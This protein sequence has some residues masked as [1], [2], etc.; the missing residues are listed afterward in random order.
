MSIK[1]AK[2]RWRERLLS[3]PAPR[4]DWG[5]GY[6]PGYGQGIPIVTD[7]EAPYA[8][9]SLLS[10]ELAAH[11]PPMRSGDFASTIRRDLTLARIQDVVRN[12]PHAASAIDKLSDHI[13]GAEL[14]WMSRPDG[15]ALGISDRDALRSLAKQ[16]EAEWRLFA[17]DPRRFCDSTRRLSFNGLMR[18]CVRTALISG[19]NCYGL[20]KQKDPRARY[21]TAVLTI[22]PDRMCNPYGE[23]DTLT[24]RMGVEMDPDNGAPVGYWVRDAHLGDYWAPFEQMSW[25]FLPRETEWG[26]PVFVHAYE[27]LRDGDSRGTSPLITL[28]GRLRA[29]GR[30]TDSELASAAINALFSAT[31]ES[32]A[33]A[34]E[35]AER[36]TPKAQV[37]TAAKNWLDALSWYEKY[38]VRVGGAR[39]P[40]LLPGTTMKFNASPRQTAAFASFETAFLQTISSKLGLAYEQLKMDWSRTNYSS[41]RAALNEVWRG[42][43]RLRSAFVDQTVSPL[44]L[45][46]ADEAFDRGY[47]TEPK[48]APSFWDAVGAYLRG[49][50]IGPARGYV[51]PVKEMQASALR[52]DGRVSTWADECAEQGKDYE[53]V[54]DQLAIE[55]Q[56]LRERDLGDMP[57]TGAMLRGPTA[58]EDKEDTEQ[59][60]PSKAGA[61]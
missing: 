22:D 13:V 40:V 45:A 2:A 8:A 29:L 20:T 49:R 51:D 44:H 46:W 16:M 42:I 6:G 19:E 37:K 9:Q 39:I 26:R 18:Q 1:E 11:R 58:D 4:A 53:E 31:I 43:Y 25:S 10:Q 59:T 38:P 33:P 47:L 3:P 34:D 24:R 7:Y 35:V 32:D 27:P 41:A 28:I 61:E 55:Q 52:I 60:P 50:W 15:A 56:M 36:L 54:F 57:L 21:Q 23:R 17:D 30:F 14:R 5:D 48:G 12:D